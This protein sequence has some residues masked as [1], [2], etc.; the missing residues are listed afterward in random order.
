[1]QTFW[2]IKY[3]KH[4]VHH[5]DVI[6]YEGNILGV[7]GEFFEA[8]GRWLTILQITKLQPNL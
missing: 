6:E 2:E 5:T 4:N 3:I 8:Q 7:I 1:M